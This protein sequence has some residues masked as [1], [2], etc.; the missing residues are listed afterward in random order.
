MYAVVT[1]FLSF[2]PRN[3]K[4]VEVPHSTENFLVSCMPLNTC[5]CV[6]PFQAI[7][8]STYFWEECSLDLDNE[9]EVLNTSLHRCEL[10]LV[11][12]GSVYHESRRVYTP[13]LVFF[14]TP[15]KFFNKSLLLLEA[16]SS[17]CFLEKEGKLFCCA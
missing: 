9:L 7:Q 14:Q 3:V 12:Y 10:A 8:I 11:L 15:N 6:F 17:L 16:K 13:Q 2:E 1:Y 4:G 5:T